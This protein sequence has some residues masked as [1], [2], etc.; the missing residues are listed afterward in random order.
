MAALLSLQVTVYGS[1][2]NGFTPVDM[3]FP[4]STIL[5]REIPATDY[6]GTTCNTAIQLLPTGLNVNSP[7]F[8]VVESVST[9]QEMINGI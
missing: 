6:S 5:L 9:L 2:G 7:Q 3:A 8:Y 4:T 1:N